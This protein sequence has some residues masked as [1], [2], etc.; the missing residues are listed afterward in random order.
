MN[1]Y[2]TL[3]HQTA[4]IDEF[5]RGATVVSVLSRKKRQLEFNFILNGNAVQLVFH[6]A[7]QSALFLQDG[8]NDSRTNAA[9]FFDEIWGMSVLNVVLDS[10]DRIIKMSLQDGFE[11]SLFAYGPKSNAFLYINGELTDQFRNTS[12]ADRKYEYMQGSVETVDVA[13]TTR[14]KILVRDPRFPRQWIDKM[15]ATLELE[16]Y[17]SAELCMMVDKLTD[18]MLNKPVFRR[19]SDN[20]ICLL[21]DTYVPDPS[22]TVHGDA[23]TMVRSCW[24]Q[25]EIRDRY[26]S[27]RNQL[28]SEL[29]AADRRL[30]SILEGLQDDTKSLQR[31]DHY[32]ILGHILMAYSYMSIPDCDSVEL[33]DIF[34]PPSKVTVKVKK[35][36]SFSEN[37]QLYYQKAKNTRRTLEANKERMVDTMGKLKQLQ[38]LRAAFT[39]VDGPKTLDRWLKSNER[40]MSMLLPSSQLGVGSGKPWRSLNIGNYDVWIGK[41]A[42]GNDELLQASHKED[43]WFHARHVS[44]S[45]VIIRMARN[46]GFP[47]NEVIHEVASWAA[48]FSKAKTAGMVPVLYTKRKHVRK[49]KGAAPGSVLVDKEQVCLVEPTKPQNSVSE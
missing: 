1:N 30:R 19:L 32:E 26:V 7:N 24:V 28:E 29:E 42:A 31:A 20:S 21:P 8:M 4:F 13:K 10:A 16:S 18:T 49:P 5:L 17:G 6:T 34:N 27:R 46:A 44:G 37:A 2:Y 40:V 22:A 45:H 43:I 25:R 12:P 35:G 47:S 48:W 9:S 14:D 38:M 41:S 11:L 15:I 33:E 23:N 36:V 39:D 3:H